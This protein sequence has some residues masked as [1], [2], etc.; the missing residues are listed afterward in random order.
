[1]D[2]KTAF[3]IAIL[4]LSACAD[5]ANSFPAPPPTPLGGPQTSGPT[6][7]AGGSPSANSTFSCCING[8]FYTCPDSAAADQCAGAGGLDACLAECGMGPD[9]FPDFGCEEACFNGVGDPDP[10]ACA[11]DESKDG[12]CTSPPSPGQG[13]PGINACNGI[14]QSKC[15]YDHQ[16]SDGHCTNGNCYKDW[17]GNPCDYD[18]HCDSRNCTNNCC[19]NNTKGSA[20]GYDHHC[21]S[22]NCTGGTCQ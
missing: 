13:G 18:H 12:T 6:P 9:S 15:S 22:R 14:S 8:A 3:I 7:S 19:Q 2:L 1:M 5:G 4:P 11:R 16:C 20:C 17:T 10:S 21:D